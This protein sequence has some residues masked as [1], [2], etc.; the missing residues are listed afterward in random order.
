MRR[1]SWF[2]AAAIF[3]CGGS[4]VWGQAVPPSAP[5][6]VQLPSF[7]FFTVQTTVSV[8]D[9]G[10]MRVGGI[11]RGADGRATRGLGPLANRGGGSSRGASDVSATATII[12][13]R[14]L[15]AAVLAAAAGGGAAE[16]TAAKAAALSRNVGRPAG[17]PLPG[18]VAAIRAQNAAAAEQRNAGL[19][20]L[21][22]KAQGAETGGKLELAKAYYRM[23]ARQAT[24]DLQQ[25]AQSRLAALSVSNSATVAKR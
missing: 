19:A 2:A 25:Q 21:L 16:I 6:T 13:H 10:G 3:V 23:L 5:T 17:N 4:S 7:S 20:E 12:D 22:E 18:S 1:L 9:S 14:E 24:G 11:S 15:D 8:P